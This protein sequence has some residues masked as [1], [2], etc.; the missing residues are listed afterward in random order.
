MLLI[1]ITPI[2]SNMKG[3]VET[4]FNTTSAILTFILNFILSI[5]ISI[6]MLMHKDTYK[7]QMKKAFFAFFKEEKHMN[8]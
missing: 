6:Y 2:L 3:G 7:G 1:N 5:L 8:F 4:V